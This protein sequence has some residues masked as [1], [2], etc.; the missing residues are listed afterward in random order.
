MLGSRG[1]GFDAGWLNTWCPFFSNLHEK[2]LLIAKKK[3]RENGIACLRKGKLQRRKVVAR[4]K[5]SSNAT[6]SQTFRQ[7]DSLAKF[8]R[9]RNPDHDS[10]KS[11][12]I[13]RLA[14]HKVTYRSHVK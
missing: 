6:P 14:H 13:T 11:W 1:S 3:C 5:M 9:S 10:Q 2:N 4:N 12:L 7:T 8:I